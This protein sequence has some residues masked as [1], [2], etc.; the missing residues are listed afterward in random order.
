MNNNMIKI[1][2]MRII[3]TIFIKLLKYHYDYNYD[4][5][6]GWSLSS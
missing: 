5:G 3:M 6:L 1:V 4:L 2:I